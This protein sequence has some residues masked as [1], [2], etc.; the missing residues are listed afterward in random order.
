MARLHTVST[1]GYYAWL[2]REPSKRSCSAA[3]RNCSSVS[4]RCT[5]ARAARMVRHVS[6]RSSHVK[7][8]TSVAKESHA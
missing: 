5:R 3:M 1:S 6:M 7:A 4:V 8:C 2:V